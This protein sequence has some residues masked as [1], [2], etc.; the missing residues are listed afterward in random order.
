MRGAGKGKSKRRPDVRSPSPQRAPPALALTRDCPSTCTQ[1]KIVP[2]L[3]PARRGHIGCSQRALQGVGAW[4]DRRLPRAY[5]NLGPCGV[6]Q[7]D[8]SVEEEL[9]SG[10]EDEEERTALET[11]VGVSARS[12]PASGASHVQGRGG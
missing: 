2:S 1:R 7:Q 9:D 11:Q 3:V 12:P 6:T 8:D 4:R 10:V 5:T